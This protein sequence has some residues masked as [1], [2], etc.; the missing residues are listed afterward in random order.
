[1]NDKHAASRYP[2][3]V[4]VPLS[5]FRTFPDYKHPSLLRTVHP[6]QDINCMERVLEL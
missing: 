5:M 2:E 3:E 1:M 6:K 4:Q